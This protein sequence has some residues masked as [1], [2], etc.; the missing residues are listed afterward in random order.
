MGAPRI[1]LAKI[2]GLDKAGQKSRITTIAHA[3]VGLWKREAAR[4][5]GSTLA[6]YQNAISV[7]AIRGDTATIALT[8]TIPVLV[9]RGMGPGGIGTQGQYD[10][11]KFVLKPG[12]KSLKMAKAGWLYVNV[13]MGFTEAAIGA[14]G[15]AG[16]VKAARSL[17]PSTSAP[18]APTIWG[19]RLGGGGRLAGLVRMAKTYAAA[20]Q[21]TYRTWR[22]MSQGGKPWIVKGVK[23]RNL[24][25]VVLEKLPQVLSELP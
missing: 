11:R 1:D 7:E 18:G 3:V 8:G 21:S 2:L 15:G 22:T 24:A 5:L 9:E 20:T 25:A 23:A 10:A 17:A 13:P 16:A 12:T 19:G 4:A 14:I 6:A